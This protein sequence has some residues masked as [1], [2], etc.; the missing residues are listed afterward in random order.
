[1]TPCD[2][3][4]R[5]LG[6]LYLTSQLG[7][8]DLIFDLVNHGNA[9]DVVIPSGKLDTDVKNVIDSIRRFHNAL[10]E[11]L[12]FWVRLAT[13]AQCKKDSLEFACSKPN[14]QPDDKGPDG[15]FLATGTTP[16][17]E[18]QSI[19]NSIYDPQ[20]LISSK[21]FRSKGRIANKKGKQL[22]DFYRH[23]RENFGFVRLD[24]LLSQLCKSLN[25]S[26]TREIRIGLLSQCSYNAV[27]VADNKH[28]KIELFEGYEHVTQDVKRR[29]ATYIGSSEWKEIAASTRQFIVQRLQQRGIA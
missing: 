26:T 10:S 22:E 19:K 21:P 11:N 1:M 24:D 16:Q 29:I 13:A 17:V 2:S 12:A 25:L 9:Q 6:H 15:L 27:V 4:I 8:S 28:A 23:A 14:V 20:S 3:V 5:A 18:V 7:D